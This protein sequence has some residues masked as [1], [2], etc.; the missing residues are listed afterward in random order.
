[1]IIKYKL[2]ELKNSKKESLSFFLNAFY[3]YKSLYKIYIP[4]KLPNEIKNEL[5]MLTFFYKNHL[6]YMS[7]HQE[8]KYA[9]LNITKTTFKKIIRN[10]IGNEIIK[11]WNENNQIFYDIENHYIVKNYQKRYYQKQEIK[12]IAGFLNRLIIKFTPDKIIKQRK[13]NL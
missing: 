12:M 2:F 3:N 8:F 13:F 5:E 10:Y 11:K 9:D 1:M 7:W 4:K 6:D